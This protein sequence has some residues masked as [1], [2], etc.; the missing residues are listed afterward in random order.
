MRSQ[1]FFIFFNGAYT[2]FLPREGENAT[3][4]IGRLEQKCQ[5]RPARQKNIFLPNEPEVPD[6]EGFT[7]DL[8]R[9]KN[10]T[11]THHRKI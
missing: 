2:I 5:F 3:F 4:A 11:Y 9:Q 10:S 6:R 7:S 8:A 1:A